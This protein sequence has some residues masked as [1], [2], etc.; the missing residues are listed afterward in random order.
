[1]PHQSKK[2]SIL[3]LLFR[4][5]LFSFLRSVHSVFV[6]GICVFVCVL[7]CIVD[8]KTE[9]REVIMRSCFGIRVKIQVKKVFW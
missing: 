6:L 2:Q 3:L 8:H 4:F 1:M 9:E 7:S 5:N